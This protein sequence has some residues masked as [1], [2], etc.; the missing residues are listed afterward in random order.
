MKG[1]TGT[2]RQS[3]AKGSYG[4]DT[5]GKVMWAMESGQQT[6]TQCQLIGV[7][8][9]RGAPPLPSTG[10]EWTERFPFGE[11]QPHSPEDKGR[12]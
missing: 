4:L 5:Y 9:N 6:V 8:R 2:N 12:P 3:Q 10:T 7:E 1:F 11:L